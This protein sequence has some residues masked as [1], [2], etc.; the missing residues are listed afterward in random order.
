M[1][2]RKL[3]LIFLFASFFFV[4]RKD[5]AASDI[6]EPQ[7]DVCPPI[8]I[9]VDKKVQDPRDGRF[10]D[11]LDFTDHEFFAGDEVVFRIRMENTGE[12]DFDRVEVRDTLPSFLEFVSGDLDFDITDFDRNE[13][14]ERDIRVRV[15]SEDRFPKDKDVICDFNEV[16]VKADGIEDKDTSRICV[17]RREVVERKPT[18]LP[19]TGSGAM[20][21]TLGLSLVN[22]LLGLA[23]VF[24]GKKR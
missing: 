22:G 14:E 16:A 12:R 17:S 13:V 5:A 10:V 23:L 9:D 19:K 21:A 20:P 18:V 11:N 7:Y 24:F 8:E 6:C 2:L 4:L 15:V 3:G 1:T